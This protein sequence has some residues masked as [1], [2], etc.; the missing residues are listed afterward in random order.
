MK[1]IAM[2][3]I[4][5]LCMFMA[6][7]CAT[8][9]SRRANGDVSVKTYDRKVSEKIADDSSDYVVGPRVAEI[10]KD[11]PDATVIT[12]GMTYIP[13]GESATQNGGFVNETEHK[14]YVRIYWNKNEVV[15]FHVLPGQVYEFG[16][17]PREGY[18]CLVKRSDGKGSQ[19]RYVFD[20]NAIR[21]DNPYK[22]KKYDFLRKQN[23][24]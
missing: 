23:W 3:G 7:A 1:R 19:R 5:L 6:N 4:L 10:I 22:G 16:L 18:V 17:A 11:H 8:K 13:P 15:S 14:L 12:P 24:I 21:Q 20:V 9:I 2:V